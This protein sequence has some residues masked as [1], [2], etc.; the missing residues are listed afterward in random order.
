M[1]FFL[2]RLRYRY[3]LEQTK[4]PQEVQNKLLNQIIRD[5]KQTKYARDH[6]LNSIK[7]FKSLPLNTY[8]HLSPYLVS[9]FKTY[10][11]SIVPSRPSHWEKTSGSTGIQ[12]LIPYNRK[13]LKSFHQMIYL[14]L[15]DLSLNF[16]NFESFKIF[17]SLS[18]PDFTNTEEQI[19]FQDDTDYLPSW[20]RNWVQQYLVNPPK[21]KA[22]RNSNDFK[23]YL[24]SYL[25][26]E[27]ELE[28]IFI[29]SP[30]Y[31]LTLLQMIEDE[32]EKILEILNLGHFVDTQGKQWIVPTK[33]KKEIDFIRANIG[34]WELLWPN[35]KLVS[36]WMDGS[37]HLFSPILK[38]KLPQARFQAKGLLATEAPITVPFEKSAAPVPLLG[39]L[40]FE[41]LDDQEQV[42]ELSELEIGQQYEMMIT[43]QA[44]LLRYRIGDIIEVVDYFNQTPALKFIGRQGNQV[45]LTG[46]KLC[47]SQINQIFNE[48]LIA[49]EQAILVPYFD[50]KCPFYYCLY[51]G[52]NPTFQ[53]EAEKKLR[54][55]FNYNQSRELGQLASLKVIP[56]D[57]CHDYYMNF[58]SNRGMLLG[59]IKY[60]CLISDLSLVEDFLY[61]ALNKKPEF[62]SN[63]PGSLASQLTR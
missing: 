46:E 24:I 39:S 42:L 25:V 21:L 34:R 19:E 44:G 62:S 35:L 60:N 47:E 63:L 20:M 13:I 14:W 1:A 33:T 12:K 2:L 30:T 32:K 22:M 50:T 11:R 59:N 4:R 52:E 3:F 15:S 53:E 31:I 28:I 56:I 27:K 45:D 16:Q 58:F 40:Y 37:A 17:Y 7:D 18:Y 10:Q 54:T 57:S 61:L 26:S 23:L 51:D 43:T 29:W 55:I 9:D 5:L 41:F 48:L 49:E 36:C 6:Q 8:Q 38:K